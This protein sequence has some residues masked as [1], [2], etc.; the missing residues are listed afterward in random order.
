MAFMLLI[1]CPWINTSEPLSLSGNLRGKVVVLDFWTYC[2]VNCLHILPD[3]HD[4]ERKYSDK[5]G[6][7]II[8]VHSAKF[9]N[10]KISSNIENAV[11]RYGITH[12]IV[13]DSEALMWNEMGI[14]CWPTIV[15]VGPDG[16]VLQTFIG[17]KKQ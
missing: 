11:A 5:D 10:E 15:V 1:A 7:A 3:L 6:L 14:Q 2:C 9:P 17:K 12:P 16:R 4:L 13:N 8:G